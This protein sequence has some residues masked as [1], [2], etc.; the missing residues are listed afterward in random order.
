M[1]SPVQVSNAHLRI[2]MRTASTAASN[3][4]FTLGSIRPERGIL[5]LGSISTVK[6]CWIWEI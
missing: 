1:F 4:V 3:G 6:S 5:L 2:G